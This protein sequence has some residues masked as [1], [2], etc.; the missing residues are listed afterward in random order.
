[1]LGLRR[2]RLPDDLTLRVR[3][4]ERQEALGSPNVQTYEH[5]PPKLAGKSDDFVAF[6][7]VKLYEFEIERD[8]RPPMVMGRQKRQICRF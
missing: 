2:Q 6:E 7:I 3:S 8:A 4:E 1:V 5:P